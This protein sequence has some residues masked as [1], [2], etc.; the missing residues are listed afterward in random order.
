MNVDSRQ[1]SKPARRIG[2]LKGVPVME[3]IT[4]GGLNIVA[5][6][7]KPIGCA[8]HR[9]LARIIAQ[10]NHPDLCIDELS[11]SE[12]ESVDVSLFAHLVP[13]WTDITDKLK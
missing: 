1:L 12:D 10:N 7:G 13:V 2:Q 9:A 6:N 8:P 11:K 3:L 4:K 5:C